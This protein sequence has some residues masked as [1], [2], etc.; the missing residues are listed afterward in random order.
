MTLFSHAYHSAGGHH[1]SAFRVYSLSFKHFYTGLHVLSICL[2]S[3]YLSALT[4]LFPNLYEHLFPQMF[5][6]LN[7]LSP[8]SIC[9]KY[10]FILKVDYYAQQIRGSTHSSLQ[11]YFSRFLLSC[12]IYHFS[13]IHFSHSALS[14]SLWSHEPQNPRPPCSSPT[15]RVHPNPCPLSRWWIQTISSSV[16]PFSSWPQSFPAS[17]SF[18][19]S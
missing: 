16:I 14:D 9:S 1:S 13:S 11:A 15:P 7:S 5:P 6:G 2:A 18:Q 8:S 3:S 10:I 12:S 19:M 4:W 17:G